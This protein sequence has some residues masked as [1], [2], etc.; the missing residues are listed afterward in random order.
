MLS[1]RLRTTTYGSPPGPHSAKTTQAGRYRH[2][3]ADS[4]A[5]SADY[6][7]QKQH[8]G[9]DGREDVV[10]LPPPQKDLGLPKLRKR[11]GKERVGQDCPGPARPLRPIPW[12][13]D[14]RQ[15]NNDEEI[16]KPEVVNP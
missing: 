11:E 6:Q 10:D 14:G 5:V 4:D 1:Q 12:R 2:R 3:S 16:S 7:D 8:A 15:S 13:T 9:R